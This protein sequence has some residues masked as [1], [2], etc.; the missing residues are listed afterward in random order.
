M[1][2]AVL[3][4]IHG[5]HVALQSVLKEIEKM[6]IRTIYVLG[7][8]V[9]YYY[10]P[11]E[12]FQLLE[13]YDTYFVLGNHEKMLM[14]AMKDK[15]YATNIMRKYGR[16]IDY[17]I[18]DLPLKYRNTI[19]AMPQHIITSIGGK[20]V[21]FCHGSL[22]DT[23]EYIYPD[24]DEAIFGRF[25]RTGLDYIFMGHTHY[26]FIRIKNEIRFVNPGSVGQAR[27]YSGLASWCIADLEH[28]CIMFK[29]TEYAKEKLIRE[30]KTIDADVSYLYDVLVR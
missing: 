4:D 2:I 6:Q 3:A 22:D 24:A 25:L 12:V 11:H 8:V 15:L 9:G 19:Q 27:D 10:H 17:A 14:K 30:I 7:D 23:C 1:R 21:A 28:D 5:N 29:H 20:N 16:G 18:R 26:P 13:A